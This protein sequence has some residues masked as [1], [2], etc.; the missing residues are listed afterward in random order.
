MAG[1][2]FRR[3]I[4]PFKGRQIIQADMIN[5]TQDIFKLLLDDFEITTE[6]A[7]GKMK[8][9]SLAKKNMDLGYAIT[10]HKSQGSTYGNVYI[11]YENF[12]RCFDEPTRRSLTYVAVSRMRNINMIYG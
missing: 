8:K 7:Y 9:H 2:I 5:R 4:D 10:V 3:R 6:E 11:D 12:S 1:Q